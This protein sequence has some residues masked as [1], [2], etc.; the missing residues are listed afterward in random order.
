MN[1][2][3]V[4]K[5]YE[6]K[7]LKPKSHEVSDLFKEVLKIS[8]AFF[9]CG[10]PETNYK[11]F[12]QKKLIDTILDKNFPNLPDDVQCAFF[13]EFHNRLAK[14]LGIPAINVYVPQKSSENGETGVVEKKVPMNYLYETNGEKFP[15]IQLQIDNKQSF[16]QSEIFGIRFEPSTDGLENISTLIHE[17]RHVAQFYAGSLLFQKNQMRNENDLNA[18]I[19]LELVG[20]TLSK[21]GEDTTPTGIIK[22]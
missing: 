15:N 8:T 21:L 14:R 10:A 1:E 20:V 6:Q 16:D 22:K 17:T 11:N 3:N 5:F 2:N 9:S 13:Q 7:N 18:I 19:F 4:N 12:S